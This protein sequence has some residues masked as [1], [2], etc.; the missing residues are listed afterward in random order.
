MEGKIKKDNSIHSELVASLATYQDSVLL[1]VSSTTTAIHRQCE[2][3]LLTK[4]IHVLNTIYYSKR[5]DTKREREGKGR[6]RAREKGEGVRGE[7][8]KEKRESKDKKRKIKM[9]NVLSFTFSL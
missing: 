6:E 1:L 5:K 9:T 7:K 2:V 3:H 4:P 8:E